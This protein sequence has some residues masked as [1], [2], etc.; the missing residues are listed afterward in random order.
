MKEEEKKEYLEHYEEK[1]KKGVPFF[2]DILFK[3]A[4]AS[5]IVFVVLLGL[6]FFLGAPLEERAN[7]ADTS[8]TPRPEWY[9]LF[10]F[11]LLKYF[12]GKLEVIGAIVLPTIV[13]L[14]LLGLP[15]LD[16]SRRR[17]FSA[18]P[19]VIGGT[20]ILMV[21]IIVLTVLSVIEAPPPAEVAQ[22]D[23][24]AALYAE[25]CAP[26]HGPSI[27]VSEGTNL[28]AVISLGQHE[29]MPAWSADLTS[30]E[31]DA[32]AGFI[33]A[34]G[35]SQL[36][37]QY[38]GDCHQVSELV[39]GDL[40]E[41]RSAVDQG[42][43]FDGHLGVEIP[44]WTQEMTSDQRT[45]LLNFLAAPDG[46]RLFAINCASC[47]GQSI[48]FA[49]EQSELEAIIRQGGLHLDMPP[50]RE[51]LDAA[52]LDALARYVVEPSSEPGAEILFASNCSACHGE[53][54]P[55]SESIDAAR[56]A[57]ASGGAHE[58]MPVWGDALTTEQLAALV[59]YT[60]SAAQGTAI[61]FGQQLFAQYCTS[62]H[63]D[64]G[65]GGPNPALPG[66][67]IAPISTSEYLETRDD[68]TLRAIIAQGQPNFG[69]SPFG[70]AFGGPLDDDEIEAIVVLMRS[71]ESDPPVDLPPEVSVPDVPLSGDEIFAAVCSQC[72]GPMGEGL[73]GPTLSGEGID[74]YSDQDL[75]AVISQGREATVML[76]FGD[77]LSSPQI[78]Q[79][80][81][82]IRGLGEPQDSS[83]GDV[84]FSGDVL[85]IFEAKCGGCHGSLGGWSAATYQ[86]VMTSGNNAPTVIPG[87]AEGSLLAK[88]LL[89]TVDQG[90][91][92]PPSGMLPQDE[93]DLILDWIAA[94]AL[95]N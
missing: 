40:L 1:K 52:Q 17:H 41:L 5:L 4:I 92:M 88:W 64:F 63:G 75:F 36:F 15:L 72:H 29:G 61:D 86:D 9:F 46:Q 87:D 54:V 79:L 77:L 53:L 11:Q 23:P 91:F 73:I 25:N 67:I 62:C 93:V 32:L 6:A 70:S 21:G 66:D 78:D 69:M 49:G 33:Q 56:E 68:A 57:I 47:H 58:T 89:G 13:L 45:T 42:P 95:D 83:P 84:S 34:P 31:I 55:R 59:S 76:A 7:P 38:C 3:D 50:W 18:R 81:R 60:Y 74:A 90:G 2:P 20:S 26:C 80:V 37:T 14:L 71:W 12:P 16:R 28:H 27:M 94:G 85:P 82:F 43:D 8:Y 44:D 65:E 35:G 22:G 51:T 48:A 10:L 39:A 24:V 19:I 30:D